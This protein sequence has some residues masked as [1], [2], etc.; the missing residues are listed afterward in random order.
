M[1]QIADGLD[2]I[3]SI[4]DMCIGC[5]GKF[6]VWDERTGMFHLLSMLTRCVNC[7]AKVNQGEFDSWQQHS[8]N[9]P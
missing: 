7:T 4:S 9:N 3:G 2:Y 6:C 1:L 8:I 5:D